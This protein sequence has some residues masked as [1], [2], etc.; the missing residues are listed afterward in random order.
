[1][2]LY[3]LKRHDESGYD[4]VNGMVVA[5]DTPAEARRLA[6]EESMGERKAT[7][8]DPKAVTVR[9]IGVAWGT[10]RRGLVLRDFKAG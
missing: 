6:A 1:M 10:V 5:A 8:L 3:L 2:Y 4:V 9:R 7:W